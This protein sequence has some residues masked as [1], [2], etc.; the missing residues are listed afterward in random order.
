[1]HQSSSDESHLNWYFRIEE[2]SSS[3]EI[4]P[5]QHQKSIN[6]TL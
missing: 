2:V 3:Q 5:C 6:N 4:E 1:M